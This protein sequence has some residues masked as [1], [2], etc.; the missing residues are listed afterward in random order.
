TSVGS[1]VRQTMR[2]GNGSLT[3]RSPMRSMPQHGHAD[4]A[5]MRVEPMLPQV[6]ALP[7]TEQ[8]PAAMHRH[9]EADP[10]EDRAHVRRHVVLAFGI[11]AEDR[12][13]IR[14]DA[15]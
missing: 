14:H 10:G 2:F 7:G 9:A 3:A 15:G 13:A 8:Q 4:L 12:V 1:S 11:V 6:D 5:L